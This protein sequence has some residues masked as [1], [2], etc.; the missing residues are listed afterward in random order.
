MPDVLTFLYFGWIQ[1]ID[2][3]ELKKQKTI[4]RI[5]AVKQTYLI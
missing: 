5:F 2:F 4:S 3:H 1:F